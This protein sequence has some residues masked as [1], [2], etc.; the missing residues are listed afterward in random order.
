[1]TRPIRAILAA[2]AALVLGTAAC[3]V[4]ALAL[5]PPRCAAQ[6]PPVEGSPAGEPGVERGEIRDEGRL[7]ITQNGKSVR[8]EDFAFENLRGALVVRAGSRPSPAGQPERPVDKSMILTVGPLDYAMGSYWSQLTVGPD[9]LRRGVEV[10]GGDTVVSVWREVNGAG[11][12]DKVAFPP[13]R[14]YILDP[15]LFTTFNFIGRTLQGKPCDHR[16]IRVF[17][18]GPRDSLVDGTVTDAG[19]ETIRWGGRPVV[20]RKLVIA[21]QKTSFTAWFTSDGRML[22]LE[23]PQAAIR[24]E[25]KAPALGPP[26]PR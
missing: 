13:G 24:V 4:A 22:R 21:D 14:V 25:R 12:G 17:V 3:A 5:V 23:Q 9:T 20:A 10:A 2:R 26:R 1:M 11:T 19:N 6:T 18:L 8:V 16:P 15:P 7:L